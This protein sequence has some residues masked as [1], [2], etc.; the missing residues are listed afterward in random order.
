MR[1][2]MGKTK[3]NGKGGAETQH[4]GDAGEWETNPMDFTFRVRGWSQS[5]LRA[6]DMR[7]GVLKIYLYF[8]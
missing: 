3:K 8:F 2:S 5:F 7:W 6:P 1:E 4:E